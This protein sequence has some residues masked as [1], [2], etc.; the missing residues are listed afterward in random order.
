M[1]SWA[2]TWISAEGSP[3]GVSTDRYCTSPLNS[4]RP[5]PPTSASVFGFSLIA[6]LQRTDF[7]Q[8]PPVF[9]RIHATTKY[10]FVFYL[11]ADETGQFSMRLAVM[12]FT[13]Q[14]R[15]VDGSG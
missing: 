7:N 9:V 12:Q 1:A 2:I 8:V 15:T 11:H 5:V 10:V 14:Y 6:I 13:H 3:Y 4:F